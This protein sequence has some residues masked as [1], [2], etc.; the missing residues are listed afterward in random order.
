MGISNVWRGCSAVR[1]GIRPPALGA[2][3]AQI[4]STGSIGPRGSVHFSKFLSAD[5]IQAQP[6]NERDVL[7]ND[8]RRRSG[9]DPRDRSTTGPREGGAPKLRT[10]CRPRPLNNKK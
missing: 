2:A 5:A 4:I 3:L 8:F 1:T 7:F 6:A 10:L 9:R